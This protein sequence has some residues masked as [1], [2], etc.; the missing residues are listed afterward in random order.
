[1]KLRKESDKLKARF[2]QSWKGGGGR[3][4]A[5]Q[6]ADSRISSHV[7]AMEGMNVQLVYR[8]LYCDPVLLAEMLG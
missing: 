5:R 8:I 2:E 4:S 3:G 7:A 1:M 6:T